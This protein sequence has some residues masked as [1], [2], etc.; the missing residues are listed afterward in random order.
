MRQGFK[1]L[2][3]MGVFFAYLGAQDLKSRL[4]PAQEKK[5]GISFAAWWP[6]LY[7]LP[8]ADASLA[9]LAETGASWISLIV[10]CYQD[11]ISSTRIYASEATP[12]DDDLI[13]VFNVA[14]ALN[15]RVMLKPHL[16][17]WE[18][19]AP[20]RG[21]IGRAFTREEQWQDWFASYLSFIEHYALLAASQGADLFCVGTELSGTTHRGSEWK[22]IVSRVRAI[23]PGPL[24]YAANHSGE[25]TSL[26]WWDA[27][28][29]IGVDAYYPLASKN[30]PALTELKAAWQPHMATLASLVTKW[31]KPLLV[32]EIG[33][34]SLDGTA[35][36]PWDWQAQ[37][38]VDLGEQADCYQAA[39]ESLY[40]QPW[41][42]GLFWWAWSP[43]PFEGGP[44][45]NGYTPHDKPAEDVLR[46]WYGGTRRRAVGPEPESTVLRVLEVF[47]ESLEP[48]WSDCSWEAVR[49]IGAR[50]RAWSG[51]ASIRVR[52]GAWGGLS[53][54]HSR[55]HSGP[56]YRLEFWIRTESGKLPDL[57][58]YFH[59][60]DGRTSLRAPVSEKRY[61]R[62]EIVGT[63]TWWEI[64]IPLST[65]GASRRWLTRLTL[66]DRTGKETEEFW[67]DDLRFVGAV[68]R[69]E[70]SRAKKGS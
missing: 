60:E 7:S 23:F 6:G 36:R 67:I 45:D 17:L 18:D 51:Q 70:S 2:L 4:S 33:Y 3:F 47:R 57:W 25:E 69:P 54:C 22:K 12:T 1:V 64:S 59:D 5:K 40:Q 44:G 56:Y 61:S 41:L 8:E 34:R 38:P 68:R 58:V 15:L 35:S 66:Q 11:N 32:T 29:Y 43:D 28:D 21:Q 39:F 52:L 50:E 9:H 55:F 42:A 13:H 48:G 24:V 10:T 63:G 46:K 49:E 20:W 26:P 65:I 19:P 31:Q 27:V 62:R 14:R 30:N 37:G 16:D 53:F